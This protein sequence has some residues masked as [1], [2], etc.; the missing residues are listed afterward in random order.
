M[1]LL[2]YRLY[3]R[4]V[5]FKNAVIYVFCFYFILFYLCIKI[6]FKDIQCKFSLSL[7]TYLFSTEKTLSSIFSPEVRILYILLNS[8]VFCHIALFYVGSQEKNLEP[9]VKKKKTLCAG[10]VHRKSFFV[11]LAQ[12]GRVWD[13]IYYYYTYF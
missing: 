3:S 6:R 11:V 7:S 4:A 1:P 5:S 9:C 8:V 12:F 13:I 2:R 10:T